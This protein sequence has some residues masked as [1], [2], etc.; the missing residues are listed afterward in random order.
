MD[1]DHQV[2]DLHAQGRRQA[3][4]CAGP[5][6]SHASLDVPIRNARN[7]RPFGDLGLAQALLVAEA[8]QVVGKGGIVHEH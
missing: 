3:G 4:Q 2:G 1:L 6:G 7:P 5:W 8:T